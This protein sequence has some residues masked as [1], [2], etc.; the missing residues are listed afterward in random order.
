MAQKK[1]SKKTP[2]PNSSDDEYPLNKKNSTDN[3]YR[4]KKK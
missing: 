3:N 4:S 1:K 2:R